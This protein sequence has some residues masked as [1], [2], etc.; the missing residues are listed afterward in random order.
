MLITTLGTSH[1]DPTYCRFNSSTLFEL[2]GNS[3]LIDTGAPVN[4]LMIRKG[5][6]LNSLKAVFI[7]HMHDDHVGGLPGLIKSLIKYPEPGQH[8]DIYLPEEDAIYPL[9]QWLRAQHLVPSTNLITFKCVNPG[10]IYE[11]SDIKVQ[12]IAT[13][14]IESDNNNPITYAYIIEWGDKSLLYSGDLKYDFSDFPEIAQKKLFNLCIC[15]AT[16]Y[17]PQ[18]A[19]PILKKCKFEKLIFNH[20]HNP[21]HEEGENKLK[22]IYSELPYPI[23]V[24][25]DGDEFSV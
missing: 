12:A 20:I 3:Y 23:A 2:R 9:K 19:L 18:K 15:E 22:E 11:N 14:H 16:H 4:A 17:P 13:R 24:A 7:T 5:K 10:I 8:T 21:W 25:H 6:K 1:G